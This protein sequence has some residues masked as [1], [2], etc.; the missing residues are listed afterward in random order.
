MFK[1]RKTRRRIKRLEIAVPLHIKLL[2]M[3]KDPPTIETATRNIS[4]VGISM[5]LP[6]ALTKGA[7][8]IR[9]GEKPINLIPYLALDKKEVTL[10][11]TLPPHEEQIRAKGKIIWYDFGTRETSYYFE[12][13]I[14]LKEMEFEDRKRWEEF[15]IKAALSTGNI[16]K[17]LQIA[18]IFTFL[19]GIGIFIAGFFS[20]VPTT[21][22]IG[23]VFSFIGLI[24]SVLGWW[25][26]RSFLLL[27]KFKLY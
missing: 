6:V 8:F 21:A 16:W 22:K 13:G 19:A 27:K 5:E 3:S 7:F 20:N 1:Q 25:Q 17:Y 14:F 10:K 26:H 23:I 11:M 15:T 24:C 2:G 9:E 4:P 12:A 18:G